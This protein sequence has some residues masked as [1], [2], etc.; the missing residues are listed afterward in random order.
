MG[1]FTEWISGLIRGDSGYYEDGEH[2]GGY[3]NGYDD[4]Q[5]QHYAQQPYQNQQ[6]E[7]QAAPRRETIS[8]DIVLV[9]ARDQADAVRVASLLRE[10]NGVILNL[11][12][13]NAENRRRIEDFV[14]GAV[15]IANGKLER[16]N[17]DTLVI[18]PPTLKIKND[19]QTNIN[20]Q[21]GVPSMSGI[22]STP[23]GLGLQN[24]N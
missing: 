14:N 6:P 4:P 20:I 3:D 1:R 15:F 8:S 16:S 2:D 9:S 12:G 21:T 11:Y 10:G 13:V 22:P 18:M 7:Q 23:Q 24:F 5:Q 17:D 19:G